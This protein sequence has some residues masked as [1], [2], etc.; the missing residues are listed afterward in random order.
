[1]AEQ[2][3]AQVILR[4]P[5]G[6]SMLDRQ[7][8][9]TSENIAKYRV[10]QEVIKKASQKL[11]ERGFQVSSTGP[12]G[13]PSLTISGDKSLFEEVFQTN[14]ERQT[15][16]TRGMQDEVGSRSSYYAIEPLRIPS[17]LS[18]LVADVVLPTPPELFP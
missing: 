15:P 5:A 18:S 16:A 2:V 9:I 3:L 14:L 1:M 17:D 13:F 11:E 10:S 8:S 6:S 4:M 12:E 7:E